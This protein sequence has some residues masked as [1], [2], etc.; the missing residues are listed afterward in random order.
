[1]VLW[2][3]GCGFAAVCLRAWVSGRSAVVGV[4]GEFPVSIDVASEAGT[5]SWARLA[6]LTP[7]AFG[8]LSVDETWWLLGFVGHGIRERSTVWVNEWNDEEVIFVQERCGGI[9]AGF[10]PIDKLCGDVFNYLLMSEFQID[11]ESDHV[12][13]FVERTGAAIHSRA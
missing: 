10:I 11:V 3:V 5:V 1:M 8:C 6:V 2:C 12:I 7:E 13:H 9:I 4:P